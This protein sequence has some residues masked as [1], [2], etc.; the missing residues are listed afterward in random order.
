MPIPNLIT[1]QEVAN[2]LRLS[3]RTIYRWLAEEKFPEGTVYK[4]G[5]GWRF[6]SDRLT[7]LTIERM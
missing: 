3:R 1:P 4:V 2:R 5:R 7:D 6:N